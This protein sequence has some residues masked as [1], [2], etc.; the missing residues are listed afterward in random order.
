MEFKSD[1]PV[2]EW[3]KHWIN[4]FCLQKYG[5][6][7]SFI[8]NR[9]FWT[10]STSR[11]KQS[12]CSTA[13]GHNNVSKC[14]RSQ[15]CSESCSK[16]YSWQQALLPLPFTSSGSRLLLGRSVRTLV[17][18]VF[19]SCKHSSSLFGISMRPSVGYPTAAADLLILM[20]LK[21]EKVS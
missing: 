5:S 13:K 17:S 12:A 11:S 21:R 20:E 8:S 18:R 19:G 6:A 2:T 16:E 1:C 9:E 14:C 15:M 10:T 3:W 4:V 7:L